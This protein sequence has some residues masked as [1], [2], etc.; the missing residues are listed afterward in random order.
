MN[1]ATPGSTTTRQQTVRNPAT[2]VVPVKEEEATKEE[3]AN[4]EELHICAI[5]LVQINAGESIIECKNKHKKHKFHENCINDMRAHDGPQT[6][7][8]CRVSFF[9]DE[10]EKIFQL[11][12]DHELKKII[13]SYH[14]IYLAWESFL[15][16]NKTRSEKIVSIEQLEEIDRISFRKFKVFI[17]IIYFLKIFIFFNDN[18]NQENLEQF[19]RI[20]RKREDSTDYFLTFLTKWYEEEQLVIGNRDNFD[21]DNNNDMHDVFVL[22]K[23]NF[24]DILQRYLDKCPANLYGFFE[25]MITLFLKFKETFDK[26]KMLYYDKYGADDIIIMTKFLDNNIKQK[27]MDTEKWLKLKLTNY[28]S[29][30]RDAKSVKTIYIYIGLYYFLKYFFNLDDEEFCL[31]ELENFRIAFNIGKIKSYFERVIA[32]QQNPV[33]LTTEKFYEIIFKPYIEK[34]INNLVY[35]FDEIFAL[36]IK[37]HEAIYDDLDD[38]I[39]D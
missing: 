26:L 28:L 30:N 32:T 24:N 38:I 5:C 29:D 34:S 37:M 10:N 20:Y 12:S 2:K 18:E 3:A 15:E 33:Y 21:N 39:D 36:F 4:E 27:L 1:P 25:C 35:F 16:K 11:F 23:K 13:P 14:T 17:H 6:C 31:E 7:P 9:G 19:R 22:N 8:L